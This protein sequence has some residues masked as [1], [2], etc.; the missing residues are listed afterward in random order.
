MINAPVC[1]KQTEVVLSQTDDQRRI[2]LCEHGLIHIRWGEH[3]LVYCPG[4][5]IG[6]S[7]WLW[8]AKMS[9]DMECLHGKACRKESGDGLVYLP[10]GSVQVPFSVEECLRLHHAVQEAVGELRRTQNTGG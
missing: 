2:Y 4:D 9:C 3:R 8:S 10:Y 6:L 7:Y 1:W 5:L